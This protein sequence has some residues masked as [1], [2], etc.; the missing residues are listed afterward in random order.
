[1]GLVTLTHTPSP[2]GFLGELLERP[3]NEK[4]FLVMPVG[5]PAV[6][7]QVPALTR[8]SLDAIAVFR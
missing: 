3:A 8:K 7:A 6:D 1:M 5:Y 2:M 4:A